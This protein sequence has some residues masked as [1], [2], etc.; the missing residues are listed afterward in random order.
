MKAAGFAKKGR[1]FRLAASNGDHAI[2]LVDADAVDPERYVFDVSFWMVPLPYWEFLRRDSE[3]PSPLDTSG[4]LATCPVVPPKKVAYR[5]D[6]DGHFRNRWAFTEPDTRDLCG[7][8]LARVL[9]E[10]AIPRMVRL[11]DRGT[12]LAETRSNP[13]EGLVRLKNERMSRIVLRIDDDPVAEVTDL[14]DK[15]EAD[16]LFPPFVLWARER[17]ARRAAQEG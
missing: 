3:K 14:I 4:A 12:L 9:V 8:E 5:P 17:L 10:E 13:N 2:V 15:A 11:L 1:S 16:G 7:R 6:D